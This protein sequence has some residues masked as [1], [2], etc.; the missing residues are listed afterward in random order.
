MR[1]QMYSLIVFFALLAPPVVA[2][3][4]MGL[5]IGGLAAPS[6]G[7]EIMSKARCQ[8]LL[9]GRIFPEGEP[10][11]KD[12]RVVKLRIGE[13][14]VPM[15][16]DPEGENPYDPK[17]QAFRFDRL[18]EVYD[19]LLRITVAVRVEHKDDM[20]QLEDRRDSS[21]ALRVDGC[22]RGWVMPVFEISSVRRSH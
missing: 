14:V 5:S 8:I 3:A 7:G 11:P 13:S 6:L 21:D 18:K 22:A 20:A 4:Q 17:Y 10:I 1:C 9:S 19:S 12:L 16:L 2:Q 15:V